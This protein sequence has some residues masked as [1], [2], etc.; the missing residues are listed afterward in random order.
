[1][2]KTVGIILG[3]VFIIIGVLGYISNP[4]VGAGSLFETDGVH[5]II[6]ILSGIIILALAAKGEM[7]AKLAFKIFGI[8]YLVVA[9]LGFVGA[10]SGSIFNL[11]A[12]NAADNWLHV[13]L[14][15]LMVSLGFMGG[16][17]MAASGPS[18]G[19]PTEPGPGA[20]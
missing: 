19:T 2:A 6:H 3:I 4:I 7:K 10:S 5:N 14:G 11:I 13:V 1:M 15:I 17:P 18:M 8:V 16:R 12:I 9:V 20:V